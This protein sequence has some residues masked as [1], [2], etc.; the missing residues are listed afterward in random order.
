MWYVAVHMGRKLNRSKKE[1]LSTPSTETDT[2]S[3]ARALT[4]RGHQMGAN[5]AIFAV[6]VQRTF[7][8]HEPN[9]IVE[10]RCH[11]CNIEWLLLLDWI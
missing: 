10:F 1:A 5:M 4:L 7:T 11:M 2:I 6:R 8:Y 3:P 9:Q